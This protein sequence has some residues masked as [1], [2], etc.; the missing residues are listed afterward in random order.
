MAIRF[1]LPLLATLVACGNSYPID[2][3]PIGP[4]GCLEG[5]AG[6]ACVCPDRGGLCR[7]G[8]V[9]DITCVDGIWEQTDAWCDPSAVPLVLSED[10]AGS[11]EMCIRDRHAVYSGL[12]PGDGGPLVDV[13]WNGGSHGSAAPSHSPGQHRTIVSA[14]VK[15]LSLIHI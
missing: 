12:R 7:A 10:A 2:P 6:E 15:G 8:L 13:H 4:P 9:F 14:S 5:D 3:S 1:A 11:M